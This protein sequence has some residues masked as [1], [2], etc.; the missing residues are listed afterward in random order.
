VVEGE[1]RESYYRSVFDVWAELD[2]HNGAEFLFADDFQE[3]WIEGHESDFVGF[4]YVSFSCFFS[5]VN[6]SISS[7]FLI[8]GPRPKY[9]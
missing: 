8:T 2:G 1:S 5:L 9:K 7:F 3:Y 6:F 4:G